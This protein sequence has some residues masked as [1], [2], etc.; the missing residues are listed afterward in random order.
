M[1]PCGSF[2]L[3]CHSVI[4]SNCCLLTWARQWPGCN[5]QIPSYLCLP[6]ISPS[7]WPATQ[8][9]VCLHSPGSNWT[10][11]QNSVTI[12]QCYNHTVNKNNYNTKNIFLWLLQSSFHLEQSSGKHYRSEWV[13]LLYNVKQKW[14]VKRCSKGWFLKIVLF[15]AWCLADCMTVS[16]IHWHHNHVTEVH[17]FMREYICGL[18]FLVWKYDNISYAS[19]NKDQ[20]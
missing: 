9:S 4:S 1:C 20:Y 12:K 14:I 15:L 18:M 7:H 2:D 5:W 17:T 8:Q 3:T 10:H 19:K 13:K 6:A 16:C 11:H